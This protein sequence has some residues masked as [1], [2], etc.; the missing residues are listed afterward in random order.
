MTKARTLADFDPSA[1]VGNT[2][3]P[4]FRAYLNTAQNLSSGSQ[5]LVN[6]NGESFDTD[7]KYDNTTY[8]FTP[9]VAGHYFLKAM[10]T[11][12]SSADFNHALVAIYKNGSNAAI[13]TSEHDNYNSVAVSTM[14]DADADDYFE[15]KAYQNNGSSIG[16]VVDES[17][18]YFMGYKI[19]T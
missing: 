16:L 3:T 9:T 10:V 8:R 15:V 2:N 11:F 12:A 4:A 1:Q 6:F 18:T 19:I 17:K 7:N 13:A 5:Q 14:I